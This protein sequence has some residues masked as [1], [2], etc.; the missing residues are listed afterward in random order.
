MMVKCT[1]ESVITCRLHIYCCMLMTA[2]DKIDVEKVKAQ[3]NQ[4]FKINDL[5]IAR[6]ILGIK[7]LRDKKAERLYFS[8][9]GRTEKLFYGFNMLNAKVISTLWA[10]HFALPSNL[11][12]LSNEDIDYISRVSYLS[13][14]GSLIYAMVLQARIW[15]INQ[16]SQ[17]IPTKS[18]Q[19]TLEMQLDKYLDT[20][21]APLMLV[22]IFV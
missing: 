18:W 4:E 15:Y 11:C 19:G 5:G 16:C 12:P 1:S 3:L 6:K 7:I 10:A 22:C 17:Q 14:R 20:G 8:Q 9:K 21:V 13:A 2:K